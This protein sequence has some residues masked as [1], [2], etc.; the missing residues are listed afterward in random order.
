[1]KK[2]LCAIFLTVVVLF[3]G[4]SMLQDNHDSTGENSVTESSIPDIGNTK[5]PTKYEM[6]FSNNLV[7]YQLSRDSFASFLQNPLYSF[8]THNCESSARYEKGE[9]RHV[10]YGGSLFTINDDLVRFWGNSNK[11]K[12]YLSQ[13]DVSG[14]LE[15]MAVIDAPNVPITLWIKTTK[16]NVFVTINEKPDDQRYVYRIYTHKV[17]Q[18]RYLCKEAK[19][20]VKGKE[21]VC[22]PAPKLYYDYAD[23]PFTDVMR[24]LG[25]KI[26]QKSNG[27]TKIKYNGK[28]YE[29][30]VVNT[31]LYQ[32]KDKSFNMFYVLDGGPCFIYEEKGEVMVDSAT[33]L[34]V[35]SYMGEKVMIE[36][37]ATNK[38]V[39]IN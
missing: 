17:F 25:A 14:S 20:F 28:V 35:L 18:Q 21:V 1:M 19:L 34:C 5:V 26:T 23:V 6:I 31:A 9:K 4:C 16:S 38:H 36:T 13:N 3:S 29:L 2:R 27:N 37:D 33:L 30:D 12:A 8:L 15:C 39:I 7:V 22:N 10:S 24:A 11:V 32:R